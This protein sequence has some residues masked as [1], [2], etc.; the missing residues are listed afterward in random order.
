MAYFLCG[1]SNLL[2]LLCDVEC[3]E[4]ERER[5]RMLSEPLRKGEYLSREHRRMLLR[6]LPRISLDLSWPLSKEPFSTRMDST[7]YFFSQA[8][9]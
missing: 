2:P 6:S 8:V 9:E 7:K 1:R 5:N 3:R 4:L